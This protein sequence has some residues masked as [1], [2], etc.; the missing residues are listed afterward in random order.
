M[1]PNGSWIARQFVGINLRQNRFMCLILVVSILSLLSIRPPP[2]PFG[3]ETTLMVASSE[4]ESVLQNQQVFDTLL[5]EEARRR[6]DAMDNADLMNANQGMESI[7]IVQACFAALT[8]TLADP[9]TKELSVQPCQEPTRFHTFWAG[10]I[11]RTTRLSLMSIVH[12]HPPG[13]VV[14]DLWTVD[15]QSRAAAV[16][17]LLPYFPDHSLQ[18][19]TVNGTT[20]RDDICDTFPALKPMLE[21]RDNLFFN[22]HKPGELNLEAYSDVLRF[23][24]LAAYG[25]VYVDVDVLVLRS[26]QPLYSTDFWYRWS[27]SPYCNTAVL[28]IKKGSRDAFLLLEYVVR[29]VSSIEDMARVLHPMVVLEIQNRAGSH[30]ET[31]PSA[32]FDPSWALNDLQSPALQ[33]TASKYGM[34]SI[35]AFFQSPTENVKVLKSHEEFFTASFAYHWHNKWNSEFEENSIAAVFEQHFMALARERN[36]QFRQKQN[37]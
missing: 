25:G 24:L 34:G 28:H 12:S 8:Q 33:W 1:C 13:C 2:T 4:Q 18:V 19:R 17:V 22:L 5:Y 35:D 9:L 3:P 27:T 23:L 20:L 10:E 11:L 30:I 15:E 16:D 31:L 21:E 26:F 37:V 29:D 7:L 14:I 32:Y 6:C 36:D